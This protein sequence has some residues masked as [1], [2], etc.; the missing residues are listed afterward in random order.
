MKNSRQHASGPTPS[1][2]MKNQVAEE[3]R[4][5]RAAEAYQVKIVAEALEDGP[6]ATSFGSFFSKAAASLLRNSHEQSFIVDDPKNLNFS[7]PM[8]FQQHSDLG[9]KVHGVIQKYQGESEITVAEKVQALTEY[10]ANNEKKMGAMTLVPNGSK[11]PLLKQ[12]LHLP[13]DPLLPHDEGT[14]PWVTVSRSFAYRWGPSMFPWPSVGSYVEPQTDAGASLLLIP[15]ETLINAGV[16]VLAE[17]GKF[18]NSESGSELVKKHG[19]V[20]TWEPSSKFIAWIPF[21]WLPFH[22]N[23]SKTAP[24]FLWVL[25]ILSETLAKGVEDKVWKPMLNLCQ[26][27]SLK[28][29]GQSLWKK[30]LDALATLDSAREAKTPVA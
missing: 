5:A 26:E 11:V 3:G 13:D 9:S 22:I 10:L 19:K 7:E 6:P 2:E 25:P 24:S 1:K 15:G 30:R 20:I 18:L 21:G 16:V 28:L 23:T 27:H 8:V 12:E 17:V 29:S 14:S 4:T